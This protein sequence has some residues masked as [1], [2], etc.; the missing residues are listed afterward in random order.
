MFQ[1]KVLEKIKTRVLYSLIFPP[2][3]RV[4][5]EIMSKNMVEPERPQIVWRMLVACWISKTELVKAHAH[6]RAP[7]PTPTHIQKCVRLSFFTATVVS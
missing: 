1:I 5:N 2:E 6:S 3:N 7:T 4:V